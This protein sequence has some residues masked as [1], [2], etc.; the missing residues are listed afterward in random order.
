VIV[1][2]SGG[3]GGG[4]SWLIVVLIG[5]VALF[6][7]P[8]IIAWIIGQISMTTR[9]I[10]AVVTE[11]AGLPLTVGAGLSQVAT[12]TDSAG[13]KAQA[14]QL[15]ELTRVND[16]TAAAIVAKRKLL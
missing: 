15:A 7:G 2:G 16:G 11:S 6:M 8:K 14:A 4:T 13:Y 9:G 12:A 5:A 3:G 10:G 1:A